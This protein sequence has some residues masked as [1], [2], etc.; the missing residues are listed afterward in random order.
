MLPRASLKHQKFTISLVFLA[1]F[2]LVFI[3]R[4]T[5]Q[6]FP[7]IPMYGLFSTVLLFNVFYGKNE[8]DFKTYIVLILSLSVVYRL[9]IFLFPE[10]LIGMDPDAFATWAQVTKLTGS[11]YIGDSF[12]SSAPLFH[13]L[14][15]LT[16]S[17]GQISTPDS[18]VISVLIQAI[19]PIIILVSIS[20]IL[21]ISDKH[22]CAIATLIIV[23]SHSVKSS[24]W[25]IAQGLGDSYLILVILL[26]FILIRVNS[27]KIVILF[28]VFLTA[29]AFTHKIQI[30]VITLVVIFAMSFAYIFSKSFEQ[31]SSSY[32]AE[33]WFILSISTLFLALQ[34]L[35]IESFVYTAAQKAL[36]ILSLDSVLSVISLLSSS[37]SSASPTLITG[38]TIPSYGI[39]IV[40]KLGAFSAILTLGVAGIAWLLLFLFNRS[41]IKTSFLLGS[42][43]VFA[44]LVIM[45][46]WMGFVV[47]PTRIY[48][49][50]S[51]PMILLIGKSIDGLSDYVTLHNMAKIVLVFLLVM[52][53]FSAAS[54]PNYPDRPRYYL[55]EAE[56][57]AKDFGYERV[58]DPIYTDSY[59]AKELVDVNRI[60]SENPIDEI[61][62]VKSHYNGLDRA[63]LTKQILDEKPSVIAYRRNVEIYRVSK[64]TGFPYSIYTLTWDPEDQLDVE[65]NRVYDNGD[66]SFFT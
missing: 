64:D 8:F 57:T 62:I 43:M 21:D 32:L 2:G 10:S 14:I 3:I 65:Y 54:I 25:P 37:S 58:P 12:Y 45:A 17:I 56:V 30:L 18:L 46:G 40:F 33:M 51:V 5:N 35:Y 63:L 66:V 34:W 59:Y 26:V 4:H 24:Y 50:G 20:R 11:S 1:I 44:G 9:I 55:T 28:P 42:T 41:D 48:T 31:D 60:N 29:A 61:D 22:T 19:L 49:L 13:V 52:N 36:A 38:G 47:S 16:S 39:L 23:H 15:A 53:A 6:M 7:W 27:A